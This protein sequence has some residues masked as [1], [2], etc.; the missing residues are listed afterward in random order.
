[1]EQVQVKYPTTINEGKKHKYTFWKNKPV[2]H[3]DDISVKSNNLEDLTK[4][5]IYGTNEIT[6]PVG[7]KWTEL[8]I[9]NKNIAQTISQFL[10]K[11]YLVDDSGKF[12]L[13]YTDEFLK[14]VIGND[15]MVLAILLEKN[16]A[17][18]GLV[19][20][21]FEDVT[22][23]ESTQKFA[24]VNFLCIHPTYRGKK[25]VFSLL[26]EITRRVVQKGINQGCFTTERCIPTPVTT[27]R[28]Y[29]RPLNYLKLFKLGFVDLESEKLPNKK[30]PENIQRLLNIVGKMP[31]NYILMEEKHMETVLKIYNSYIKRYN[32]YVNYNI[33]KLKLLLLNKFVKSYVILDKDNNIVDFVSYY[34]LNSFCEIH[35]NEQIKTEKINAG[36]LFLYT[37]NVIRPSDFVPNILKIASLNGLDVFNTIDNMI[38]SDELFTHESFEDYESDEE[39]FKKQYN[40]GF[41][42]GT[43][44]LHFN[45][46][47]W[48]CP[49]LQPKQISWFVL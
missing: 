33:E 20:V 7:M 23:F 16:N 45:F 26:D 48:E 12:K 15:G 30:N 19:S 6:L 2:L 44:K 49:K 9:N 8:D 11:Y 27:L 5:K 32:I 37:C 3:F 22:V 36:Y 38:M 10:I 1:M 18:C 41:L 35:E 46:F 40:Y 42:K 29:H 24:V 31:S 39:T 28:Y 34:M 25:M 21:T 13:N 43:K 17:L 4:R 47:N 14:W